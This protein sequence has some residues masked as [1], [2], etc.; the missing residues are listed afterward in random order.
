L[1]LACALVPAHAE[2]RVALVIGNDRYANLAANEQLQ[3]AVND[4]RAVGKA[5]TQLG[6][7]VMSGEN[8][9]RQALVDRIDAFARRLSAGDTAFFFFSGHG[10]SLGG[11]NY[12]L[13]ADI[14]DVE[15]DQESRLARTALSEHDIVSD[16]QA[17]G[18]RITVVVLDACRTNPFRRTGTRSVGGEKGLTPPTPVQGVFSLYAAGAGQAAR[19]RISDDDSN[20][21]SVFTR[22]VVPALTRPGVDLTALAFDVREEVA[23]IAKL[24]GYEQRPAYYDETVGGR[25]YLA[26]APAENAGGSDTLGLP[27]APSLASSA[28]PVNRPAGEGYV[29]VLSAV[30]SEADAEAAFRQLQ[31]K[32]PVLSGRQPLI[33]RKDQGDRG[34]FLAAQVG[35]FGAKSE[36]DQLCEQLKSAGG[37][38]FVQRD[39]AQLGVGT[40]AAALATSALVGGPK[41]VHTVPIR[42]DAGTKHAAA[43]DPSRSTSG[44]MTAAQK[45]VLYEEDPSNPNGTQYIGSAIWRT[46]LEPPAPGQKREVTIH[47]QIEIPEQKVSMRLSLRRN[48]DKQLPASH[49][50]EIVFTLP[51]DFAHGGIQSIP[52]IMVKQG[53]TNRGIALNGVAVKVRN[54]YFLVGLSSADAEMQRN[55]QLLEERSWFDIPVVYADGKRALIVIEKGVPGEHAFAEAFEAWEQKAD[56]TA[57]GREAARATASTL[58][59]TPRESSTRDSNTRENSNA[60]AKKNAARASG[61]VS[62][63]IANVVAETPA[64][65]MRYN[66]PWLR[67]LILA[68]RMYRMTA[69]PQGDRDLTELR[70]LMRKPASAVA[71]SFTNDPYPGIKPN[72]F[73]GEAV[74]LLPTI[75]F[76][77]PTVWL[78]R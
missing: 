51:P 33:R 46:E 25:F 71:M 13:P 5:L 20:P 9:G 67:A 58:S 54:N 42:A 15:A 76:S 16:L 77:Q 6:F 10:V 36:A 3:K 73:G 72:T 53:E 12:I 44:A 24:A 68:P 21:N 30:R 69:M 1:A 39:E 11:A 70:S 28:S 59:V 31:A 56:D 17:R 8:V 52:G 23:R 55:V 40:P 63:Q 64:P 65:G 43:P 61:S 18:V 45:V 47:G 4:A 60:G 57:P 41:R 75:T 22:V 32:Y 7:E 66:D 29:V 49:T 27:R 35:P 14:P 62:I 50:V 74:V 38:C 19:D 48:D 2:K 37:S 34:T 78:Q 26:A